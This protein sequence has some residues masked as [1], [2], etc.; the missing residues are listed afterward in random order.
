[1]REAAGHPAIAAA[2]ASALFISI[3]SYPPPAV[4]ARLPA[5]PGVARITSMSGDV[6]IRRGDTHTSVAASN[7]APVL[8]G[9]RISTGNRGRAVVQMDGRSS[10]R[11]GSNTELRFV[12]LNRGHREA[13][14][15]QG[16]VGL[17]LIGGSDGRPQI[18]TP[19]VAVRP[20]RSGSYR[21]R[22]TGRG[23]TQITVRSGQAD[24]L[25]PGRTI[26]LR[27]GSTLTAT[28][29][30]IIGYV[31]AVGY[32]SFDGWN[33]ALDVQAEAAL[34]D[35]Y[36]NATIAF[37][38]FAGYGQW[39]VVANYGNVWVPDVTP[40][41]APYRDGRWVWEDGYGWTWVDYD[42]WGWTPFHYGSWYR[43]DM[44]G[45]AWVPPAVAIEPVYV[46]ARVAFFTYGAPDFSIGIAFG[47]IG[48]VPLTPY[49]EYHP[50][51]GWRG[52]DFVAS[53]TVVN[54]Q[55]NGVAFTRMYANARRGAATGIAYQ[56]FRGGRFGRLQAVDAPRIRGARVVRGAVPVVPTQSNLRFG[57]RS[58]P[59]QLA[60]RSIPQRNFAGNAAIARRSSFQQQSRNL[61]SRIGPAIGAPRHQTT[62]ASNRFSAAHGTT[63]HQANAMVHHQANA[64]VHHQA[65]AMVHHQANV[66]VQRQ[67]AVHS[68]RA[69]TAVHS[70]HQPAAPRQPAARS[71]RAPVYHAAHQSAPQMYRGG[72]RG[73]NA[74]R[75]AP[76]GQSPHSGGGGGGPD[77]KHAGG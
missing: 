34:S 15:A 35:P 30:P 72:P 24:V 39:V 60:M 74:P 71:Y 61:A 19:S 36:V 55:V 27:P 70:Y 47:D 77:H 64:M 14:L 12:N 29:D 66:N 76:A 20:D 49:E 51:Y 41:W 37:D 10:I 67:P 50:W 3:V 26:S 13:Q 25:M 38:D 23:Q 31:A 63:A 69:A 2:I 32:D 54:A 75:G 57:G 17:R 9:D 58:I 11:V 46:P 4:G 6:A 22:V 43:S 44:Y 65:N 40:G 5:G 18:D 28:G 42:R 33:A 45:W 7:N 53:A 62:A 73:G 1:M 68:Y 48:W 52:R 56:N 16:T 8:A 21:I 59:H